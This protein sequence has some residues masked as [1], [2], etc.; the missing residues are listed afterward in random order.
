MMTARR[1]A[2]LACVL[3]LES[4]ACAP[5]G[6]LEVYIDTDMGIPNNIDAIQVMAKVNGSV[7]FDNMY[8]VSSGDHGNARLTIPGSIVFYAPESDPQAPVTVEVT[9]WRMTDES[10]EFRGFSK[11]IGSIPENGSGTMFIPLEFLCTRN[12]FLFED[13][14]SKSI[15]IRPDCPNDD[16]NEEADQVCA[17]GSCLPVDKLPELV[18][19]DAFKGALE[20]FDAHECFDSAN[21]PMESFN[22]RSVIEHCKLT[23]ASSGILREA[24]KKKTIRDINVA[25]Q[26]AHEQRHW[27]IC[28]RQENN[29]RVVPSI[30]DLNILEFINDPTN[31]NSISSINLSKEFCQGL[32]RYDG[33][34]ED[35]LLAHVTPRCPHK[36]PERP[37]CRPQSHR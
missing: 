27:G 22:L 37:L 24:L 19:F 14:S 8:S 1:M 7:K 20:C 26:L 36:T 12:A 34:V 29:C 18:E 33:I 10:L 28:D 30:P 3:A 23:L 13:P 16:L 25:F 21:V 35:V 11:R 9:A 17:S 5:S 31:Q 15:L 2:L 6:K 4:A 32:R